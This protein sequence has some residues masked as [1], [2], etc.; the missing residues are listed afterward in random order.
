M[1]DKSS[2]L[3]IR[4]SF[5]IFFVAFQFYFKV[6]D[7]FWVMSHKRRRVGVKMN[8]C[9]TGCEDLLDQSHRALF[10]A[11][12]FEFSLSVIWKFYCGLF[13]LSNSLPQIYSPAQGW[14]IRFYPNP[15]DKRFWSLRAD[16]NFFRCCSG[17]IRVDFNCFRHGFVLVWDFT[18]ANF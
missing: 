3:E 11:L 7:T 15:T 4:R 2:F 13:Q 1:G 14:V 18:C 8:S 10:L 9:S 6:L 17:S 16:V 5:K 12:Q